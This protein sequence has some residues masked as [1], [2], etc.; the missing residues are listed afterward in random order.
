MDYY[1][2]NKMKYDTRLLE[3]LPSVNW[4]AIAAYVIGILVPMIFTP[5]GLPIAIW[6]ILTSSV[7]YLVLYAVARA[8]GKKPG[9]SAIADQGA[10]PYNPEKRAVAEGEIVG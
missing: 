10:G 3:K 9:Y 1:V 4:C 5:S 6:N 8:M 2:I 7:A